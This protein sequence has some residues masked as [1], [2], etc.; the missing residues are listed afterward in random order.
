MGSE[1]GQ[2]SQ[3]S[4][5]IAIGNLA[6]NLNQN[7]Y[8]IAIGLESGQTSQGNGSIAMGYQSGQTLQST[9]TIAMG[10]EAGQT[11]QG[12]NSIAMG[13]E[14]GQISQGN[15]AIAI[16]NLAGKTNQFI[17]SIIIN[18]TGNEL[19]SIAPGFF[20]SPVM[21]TT[22]ITDRPL[23]Y[24]TLTSEITYNTVKTFVIDHPID[25]N[26]YLVHAC[27]EGPEA[28]IYYRGKGTIINNNNISIQLP[29]YLKYIGKN[30]SINITRIF[31]GIKVNEQYE[32]SEIN[33]NIFTVYGPNGS[34]Y[35][36]VYG[37]R[38]EINVEPYKN[39]VNIE[40]NGPYKYVQK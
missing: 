10:S 37:E 34:F 12:N 32:T 31:S 23:C 39:E 27:L 18:A 4:N 16:G 3:G 9:N 29:D 22:S 33:D 20:V 2:I 15:N 6:G 25:N 7:N 21:G 5:T 1:A 14:A 38:E 30:Y 17:N 8:A 13:S 28:G 11:S 36:I 26:K 24:N 35:W 19:N 40:G